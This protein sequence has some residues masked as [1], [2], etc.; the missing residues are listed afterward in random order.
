[1]CY[2]KKIQIDGGSSINNK[3]PARKLMQQILAM[4]QSQEYKHLIKGQVQNI[5]LVGGKRRRKLCSYTII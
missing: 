5:Y 4:A 2:W 1:M 3:I